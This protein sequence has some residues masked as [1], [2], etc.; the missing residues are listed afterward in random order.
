MVTQYVIMSTSVAQAVSSNSRGG[1]RM[2][3]LMIV[4]MKYRMK[5]K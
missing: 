3:A 5:M 4:D 2:A 1:I